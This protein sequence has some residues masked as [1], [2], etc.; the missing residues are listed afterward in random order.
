MRI[1][2]PL[3]CACDDGVLLTNVAVTETEWTAGTYTIGQQRYVD[4]QLYE[5]VVSST[6]DEP[7]AG[8]AKPEP[9]WVNIGAI[10]RF[11]MFDLV[12]GARTTL[13][14]DLEVSLTPTERFAAV[15]FFGLRGADL[16]LSVELPAEG[17]IYEREVLLQDFSGITDWYDYFFGE[18]PTLE[19]VAFADVP[20]VS[21]ATVH[22]TITALD[23][24]SEC[25][26]MVVGPALEIGTTNMGTSVGI[27][28]FS[29]KE[30]DAF[31]GFRV[32]ER[33][34]SKRVDFEVTVP[35]RRADWVGQTLSRLRATPVVFVGDEREAATL[36]F[37]YVRDWKLTYRSLD[38]SDLTLEAEGLT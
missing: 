33:A 23:G 6:T 26:E 27:E 28:D 3:D 15:A 9:T 37:G 24:V 31:G 11:R 25:G 21:G 17:V 7:T 8:A 35:R 36:V 16:S 32:I 12:V 5:V 20:P 18:V 1:I 22:V 38:I 10:N 2:R 14:G 34:F 30:R 13:A 29:A 19:D 4:T